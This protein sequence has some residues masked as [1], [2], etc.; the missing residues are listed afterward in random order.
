MDNKVINTGYSIHKRREPNMATQQ[1]QS[2]TVKIN[3]V[4]DLK[5]TLAELKQKLPLQFAV[6][7]SACKLAKKVRQDVFLN[8]VEKMHGDTE[9]LMKHYHCAACRKKLNKDI[10]GNPKVAGGATKV[11]TLDDV[12]I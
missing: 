11:L 9:T 5:K 3:P 6:T 2:A 12:K 8:R 4:T 7:C 1:Q 10:I